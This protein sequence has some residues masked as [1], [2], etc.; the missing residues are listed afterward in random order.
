MLDFF[1]G[2]AVC[3]YSVATFFIVTKENIELK[4]DGKLADIAPTL[5]Q[6]LSVPI[7]A[8]M[9]GKSLIK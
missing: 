4:S 3:E 5:L 6:L 9:T 2:Y 8:D 7:P 1:M